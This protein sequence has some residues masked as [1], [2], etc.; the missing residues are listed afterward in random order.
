MKLFKSRCTK[1][2]IL[3]VAV[4]PA[5]VR[6]EDITS[7]QFIGQVFFQQLF[8]CL[9]WLIAFEIS[10]SKLFSCNFRLSTAFSLG[11]IFRVLW[12]AFTVVASKCGV[13][14][15]VLL[16][17]G[18]LDFVLVYDNKSFLRPVS[19]YCCKGEESWG[20]GLDLALTFHS[21]SA[22]QVVVVLQGLLSFPFRAVFLTII[23]GFVAHVL[24]ERPR[25]V[26]D[27]CS[28]NG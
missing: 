19:W 9:R 3:S 18:M 23:L 24:L 16:V 25:L 2:F 5:R 8:S 15:A 28:W 6:S 27:S 1:W 7:F 14:S 13:N 17:S 21:M 20:S 12:I 4:H 11:N 26:C 22:F 10:S